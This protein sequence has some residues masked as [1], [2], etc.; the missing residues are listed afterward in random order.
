[1]NYSIGTSSKI[2]GDL[3]I[4]VIFIKNIWVTVFNNNPKLKITIGIKRVELSNK[5]PNNLSPI[6]PSKSYIS[7]FY[8]NISP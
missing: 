2:R 4:L 8:S 3:L 6:S 1:M 5:Y 7:S